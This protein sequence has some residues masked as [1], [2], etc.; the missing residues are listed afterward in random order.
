MSV[1]LNAVS[2]NIASNN[3]SREIQENESYDL[4]ERAPRVKRIKSHLK[5]QIL[6]QILHNKRPTVFALAV[7]NLIIMQKPVP[8]IF[9][10]TK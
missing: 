10:H 5:P 2:D 6:N 7:N 9:N 1:G 3:I 8:L 4:E